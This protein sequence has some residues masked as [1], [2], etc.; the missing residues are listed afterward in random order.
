MIAKKKAEEESR[1]NIQEAQNS[2][3][4]KVLDAEKKVFGL[5]KELTVYKEMTLKDQ[6]LLCLEDVY[7][8]TDGNLNPLSRNLLF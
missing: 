5:N 7:M 8:S 2:W 3:L 6:G 1:R 4:S